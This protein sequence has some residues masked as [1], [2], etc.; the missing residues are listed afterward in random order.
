MAELT[1][2]C[3]LLYGI[4]SPARVGIEG[5]Q[6]DGGN[7]HLQTKWLLNAETPLSAVQV[8]LKEFGITGGC[9]CIATGDKALGECLGR[10]RLNMALFLLSEHPHLAIT[11]G[12]ARWS[13]SLLSMDFSNEFHGFS[14]DN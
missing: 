9:I 12:K 14:E 11:R 2:V 13:F 4:N 7:A 10:Y 3:A 6:V 8:V 1:E 5:M